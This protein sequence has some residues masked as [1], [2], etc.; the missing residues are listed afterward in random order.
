MMHNTFNFTT[1]DKTL[2]GEYWQPEHPKAV[3]VLL[4]G[5]GEHLGRYA[6]SVVPRLIKNNYAVVAYD[7]LG[8]GNTSGKKGHTPSYNALLDSLDNAIIKTK[9][10]FPNI[11]LML[12]GHSMGG[13]VVINY[14]LRREP[15]IKAAVATSPLLRL[16]FNPPKWKLALGKIMLNI[17]PSITLPSELDANG[18]S[19]DPIEVKRYQDDTLVHDKISPMYTFPV[20]EAGEYAIANAEKLNSPMLVCHGTG[21]QITS[22]KASQEFCDKTDNAELR[23]F[24]DG[25]HVL[26]HDLCKQEF[27][28]A[29]VELLDNQL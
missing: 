27:M 12:Y 7:Q 15:E 2:Y 1:N 3:V 18:I 26:H 9:S 4:H 19:R 22:Y 23:L 24:K 29:V 25:Y 8:H 17:F 16:A 11:P 28:T 10:L 14:V 21:D 5:M 6:Q 13:N 20:F